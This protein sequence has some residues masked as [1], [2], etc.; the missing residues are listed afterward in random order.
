MRFA[1]IRGISRSRSVLAALV[2]ALAQPL[3]AACPLVER[4][5]EGTVA[6][7]A[8]QPLA[9]VALVATWSEKK[10]ADVQA[11]GFSDANG[12]FRI[13]IQ[14]EPYSGKSIGG[15]DK[16]EAPAPVVALVVTAEGYTPYRV[17]IDLREP[18]KPLSVL[19]RRT[20]ERAAAAETGP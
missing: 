19:M 4:T 11:R 5:L 13:V 15:G 17:T 14:Y 3:G 6:D 10:A 16:C 18:P 8:E 1:S 2:L 20:G 9:G 7:S 12:A